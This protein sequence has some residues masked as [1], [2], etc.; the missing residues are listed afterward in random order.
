S[1]H[2]NV[3][4]RDR[5]RPEEGRSLDQNGML[6]PGMMRSAEYFMRRCI[7]RTCVAWIFS[8]WVLGEHFRNSASRWFSDGFIAADP[9][10]IAAYA[11]RNAEIDPDSYSAAYKVPASED[12]DLELEAISVPTLIATGDARTL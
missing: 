2:Q 6:S 4:A 12:L 5:V 3:N 9:E 10:L 1:P 7:A 8:A 11:A